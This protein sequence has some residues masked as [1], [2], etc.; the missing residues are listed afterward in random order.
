MAEFCHF[1]PS[2]A[3]RHS[4]ESLLEQSFV[5]TGALA[6]A[7][8]PVPGGV[9]LMIDATR[10]T[11]PRQAKVWGWIGLG[12]ASVLVLPF[13]ALIG[14]PMVW[15]MAE[16]MG[17]WALAL[18]CVPSDAGPSSLGAPDRDAALV[19]LLALVG[20]WRG[21]RALRRRWRRPTP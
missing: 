9:A 17:V 12:C 19:A 20:L 21:L 10:V 13:F 5:W 6:L 4:H 16:G 3:S 1:D 8:L 14:V 18:L 11:A 15:A 7:G 2:W